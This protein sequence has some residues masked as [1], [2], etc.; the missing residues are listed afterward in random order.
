VIIVLERGS[1]DAHVEE[2]RQR[3]EQRGLEVRVLLAGDK[4]AIHIVAGDSRR[5]RKLLK[6]ERVEALVPTSGPR[7][8]REGRRFWPYHFIRWSAL[9]IALV[10][11]VVL[12]AGQFPPGIG[13]PVDPRMPP[14]DLAQPWYLHFALGFVGLFPQTL[15]WVGWLLL[16]LL[17]AAFFCLPLIDRSKPGALGPRVLIGLAGVALVL[18]WVYAGFAGGVA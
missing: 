16:A 7:V 14:A 8:R 15:A 12:L 13:G 5:A 2:V 9:S 6:H 3:L 4:P 18:L 10:G 17:A 11:A 1:T